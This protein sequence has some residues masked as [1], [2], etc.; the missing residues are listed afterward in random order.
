MQSGIPALGWAKAIPLKRL[1]TV[2]D[3]ANA[4]LFP[5]TKD[6]WADHRR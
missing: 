6:H 1:G 3:I 2:E 4:A 5:A